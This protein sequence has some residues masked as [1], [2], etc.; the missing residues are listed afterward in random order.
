[1][2][3]LNINSNIHNYKVDFKKDF[4]GKIFVKSEEKSKEW[5]LVHKKKFFHC[6]IKNAFWQ[7]IKETEPVLSRIPLFNFLYILQK[8]LKA[9]EEEL[10]EKGLVDFVSDIEKVVRIRTGETDT[11]AI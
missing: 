9:K 11:E 5:I 4:F 8:I 6:R 2:K 10:K 7:E 3:T 1:M